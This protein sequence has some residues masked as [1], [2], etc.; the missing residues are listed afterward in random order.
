MSQRQPAEESANRR[1]VAG[2][3]C[4]AIARRARRKPRRRG[5]LSS[6]PIATGLRGGYHVTAADIN[7]DGKTDLLAVATGAKVDLVWFEN[8]ELDAA[9]HG[10][11]L[12]RR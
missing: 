4:S 6:T 12:S 2:R 11:G 10:V 1:I 3:P 8:P 5:I 9:R 7:K